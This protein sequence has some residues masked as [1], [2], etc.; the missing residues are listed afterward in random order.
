MSSFWQFFDSQMAIFRRVRFKPNVSV[1]SHH[2]L[3]LLQ[4]LLRWPL[5][6][7]S[8]CSP[9]RRKTIGSLGEKEAESPS[10]RRHISS[11][12]S[13]S[14]IY[15][16]YNS[17]F[18]FNYAP[19]NLESCMAFWNTILVWI[20]KCVD[21]NLLLTKIIYYW[22]TLTQKDDFFHLMW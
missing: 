11:I 15:Y 19:L 20:L 1:H 10:G 8:K 6:K 22:C 14:S 2:L 13:N 12:K 17:W 18:L 9:L 16:I 4:T 21:H 7:V 3:V 5:L